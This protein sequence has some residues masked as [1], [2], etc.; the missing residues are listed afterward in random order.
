MGTPVVVRYRPE[1][2]RL[3]RVCP[4]A[5]RCSPSSAGNRHWIDSPWPLIFMTKLSCSYGFG[6]LL[7][8]LLYSHL[9]LLHFS[10]SKNYTSKYPSIYK[11]PLCDTR[12]QISLASR[13]DWAQGCLDGV[14]KEL[15]FFPI[16]SDHKM[17]IALNC[18][19]IIKWEREII[20][21]FLPPYRSQ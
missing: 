13:L 10:T 20:S 7:E 19:I 9:I 3:G 2:I 8:L 18:L 14:K 6:E 11:T 12:R 4:M 16:I 15:I 17:Q 21:V 1:R 5:L